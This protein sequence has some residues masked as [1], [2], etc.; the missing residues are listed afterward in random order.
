MTINATA[1]PPRDRR[2][3]TFQPCTL[4]V[5]GHHGRAH[6]LNVSASSALVHV[7][8]PVHVGAQV[9]LVCGSVRCSGTSVWADGKRIGVIFDLP[10]A[11]AQLSS[12]LTVPAND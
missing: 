10:L 1:A 3:K 2:F 7:G 5:D 12:M 6:M 11:P 4:E 9:T 8:R